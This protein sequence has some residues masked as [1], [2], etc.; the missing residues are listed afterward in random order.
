MTRDK[1]SP[2]TDALIEWLL[3]DGP[4]LTADALA[5]ETG[6]EPAAV[7]RAL[8]RAKRKGLVTSR[9]IDLAYANDRVHIETR[10]EW[11]AR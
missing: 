4:W 5:M 11:A 6:R 1:A 7:D 2:R 9:R 3:L 10:T 8:K